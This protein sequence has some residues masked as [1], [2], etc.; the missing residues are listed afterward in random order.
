MSQEITY[1]LWGAFWLIAGAIGEV[2]RRWVRRNINEIKR[3]LNGE[4]DAIRRELDE[5]WTRNGGKP[6]Q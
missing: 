4:R 2:G 1:L 5:L 6:P 3:L